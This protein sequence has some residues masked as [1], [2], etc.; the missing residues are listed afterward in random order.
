MKLY[1]MSHNCVCL[2]KGGSDFPAVLVQ[3]KTSAQVP[4]SACRL[5]IHAQTVFTD[6]TGFEGSYG[7]EVKRGQKR[8]H[9]GGQRRLSG[10]EEDQREN[11]DAFKSL[12]ERGNMRKQES[13]RR[14]ERKNVRERTHRLKELKALQSKSQRVRERQSRKAR[15][16]EE[17]RGRDRRNVFHPVKHCGVGNGILCHIAP[18]NCCMVLAYRGQPVLLLD[19]YSFAETTVEPKGALPQSQNGCPHHSR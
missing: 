14:R 9:A 13:G 16:T 2:P 7:S 15:Q 19:I 17:K 12:A 1:E 5:I 18:A 8:A 6:L 3:R 10:E 4:A 11:K